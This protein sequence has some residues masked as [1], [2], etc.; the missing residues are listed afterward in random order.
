MADTVSDRNEQE[1]NF[2]LLVFEFE[3]QV[4][5]KLWNEVARIFV[6]MGFVGCTDCLGHERRDK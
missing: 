1:G 6:E 2:D 5:E 3:D 4:G